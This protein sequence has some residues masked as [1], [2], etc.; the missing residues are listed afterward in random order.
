VS[1]NRGG[2][3]FKVGDETPTGSLTKDG[4]EPGHTRL[5]LLTLN[6][7]VCDYIALCVCV[8]VC[9]CGGWGVVGWVFVSGCVSVSYVTGS[10][11]CFASSVGVFSRC[12]CLFIDAVLRVKWTK[13]V[14]L[15]LV[16]PV[17]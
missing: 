12:R 6:L 4:A 9:V 5:L 15:V 11:A 14:V 16:P 1:D 7:S 2:R 17:D 10:P 8:C 3:L 13:V